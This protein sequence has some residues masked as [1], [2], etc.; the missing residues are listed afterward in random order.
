MAHD[1][2]KSEKDLALIRRVIAREPGAD[3]EFVKRY[4][5]LILHIALKHRRPDQAEDIHQTTIARL[6]ANDLAALRAWRGEGEFKSYLGTIVT[7]ICYAYDGK[8]P[9]DESLS[10]EDPLDPAP[11]PAAD[12][13]VLDQER[14]EAVA[15]C[16]DALSTRDQLIMRLH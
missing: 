11:A 8:W 12:E 4:R 15:T 14:R 7:R 3:E 6:W 13:L 5:R 16:M 2:K 9:L 10:G 1:P